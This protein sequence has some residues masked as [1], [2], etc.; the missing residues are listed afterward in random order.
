MSKHVLLCSLGKSP[1]VV[2]EC[3]LDLRKRNKKINKLILITTKG[4]ELEEKLIK[5]GLKH[6]QSFKEFSKIEVKT[7]RIDKDDIKSVEDIRSFRRVIGQALNTLNQDE[8]ASLIVNLAGGR[9]TIPIDMYIG[10]SLREGVEETYHL[11]VEKETLIQEYQKK[12]NEKWQNKVNEF[13][14]KDELPSEFLNDLEKLFN[15]EKGFNVKV[16]LIKLPV[17]TLSRE[18]RKKIID[19]FK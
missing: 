5:L 14:E 4:T 13:Y 19:L 18:E 3:I 6:L 17:P 7:F 12:F 11:L 8:K 16:H 9:K 10:I 1:G 2:T 15:P